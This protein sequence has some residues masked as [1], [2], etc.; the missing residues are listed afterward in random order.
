MRPILRTRS[1]SGTL[2]P[3][4]MPVCGYYNRCPEDFTASSAP[5]RRCRD[6]VT[7]GSQGLRR[8]NRAA[9]SSR[10]A[11][12]CSLL[13]FPRPWGCLGRLGLIAREA[14]TSLPFR[15][16]LYRGKCFS[17]FAMSSN[18]GAP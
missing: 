5:K 8:P 11:N 16:T 12:Y 17:A 10:V 13:R 18:V 14:S 4:S 6:R 7:L 1:T 3:Q 15:P 2:T 9:R